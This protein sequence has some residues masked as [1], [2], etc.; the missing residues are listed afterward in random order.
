M[1]AEFI[2]CSLC[3]GLDFQTKGQNQGLKDC[4]PLT[5]NCDNPLNQSPLNRDT[6]LYNYINSTLYHL[7]I[8]LGHSSMF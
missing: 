4:T 8:N 5:S 7:F 2:F 6:T 3:F 1:G